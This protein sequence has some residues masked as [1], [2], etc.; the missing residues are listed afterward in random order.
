MKRG[1][2][3][4][5]LLLLAGLVAVFANDGPVL[6][7]TGQPEKSAMVSDAPDKFK[8][9]SYNMRWRGGKDLEKLIGLLRGDEEIGG[10]GVIC[11]Q[12]VDRNKKRTKNVNTARQMAQELGLHYAWAAPPSV[13][14]EA[15]EET[16]VAILS[17]YPLS[18]ATRIVLPEAGPKG[19]RRVALGVTA[20]TGTQKIRVYSLHAE[21][22]ISNKG[23]LEQFRAVLEDAKKYPLAVI[24]GDF[25]T[26]TNGAAAD[27]VKLFQEAGF[28]TPFPLDKATWRT[29][30]VELK[31][32]WLWLRGLQTNKHGIDRAVKMSDHWPLWLDVQKS[33]E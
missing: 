9:V 2:V 20:D 28:S 16:G 11:L 17:R 18:G 12:E 3:I 5:L 33:K 15:E 26:Y 32:D 24:A 29:F 7:E 22:R 31:L 8:I 1:C 25:N 21:I 19:R 27:T 6:L 30:I 10:A 23:R 14:T 13:D 4:C